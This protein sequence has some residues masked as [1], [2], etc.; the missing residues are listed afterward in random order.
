[1][2]SEKHKAAFGYSIAKNSTDSTIPPAGHMGYKHVCVKLLKCYHGVPSMEVVARDL[3]KE[4]PLLWSGCWTG[5]W[6]S[7]VLSVRFTLSR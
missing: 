4:R 7:T 1:M 6:G 2:H 3:V 5:P